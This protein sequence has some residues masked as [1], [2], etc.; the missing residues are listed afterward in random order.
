MSNNLFRRLQNLLP[1]P[2]LLVGDVVSVSDGT[3]KVQEPGG[4]V[5]LVRGTASVGQRVYFRDGVIE[6]LAPSLP[7]ELVEE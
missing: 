7:I 3:A 1:T 4:G 2:L 5:T 6:G